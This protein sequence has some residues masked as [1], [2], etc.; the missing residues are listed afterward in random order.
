MVEGIVSFI[1]GVICIAIGISNRKG[2]ISMLHSYHR[3]RV[4]EGDILPFGK[5]IGLGTIILGSGLCIMGVFSILSVLV[6]KSVFMVIGTAIMACGFIL[7]LV[8]IVWALMKYNK[9]IF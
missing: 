6:G 2:N 7:G 8:F 9:G 1:V 4:S 3:K 5:K